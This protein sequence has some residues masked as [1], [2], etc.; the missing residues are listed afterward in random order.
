MRIEDLESRISNIPTLPIVADEINRASRQDDFTA[1]SLAKII[2]KDPP[3][4]GKMLKLSNSAYY[5]FLRK[6]TTL[7]RAATLLGFHT[8]RNLA[9][10]V[11]IS[12]FFSSDHDNI[13]M[14]G[15]WHHSLGCAVA[16]KILLHGKNPKLEE[17]AF[18]C[19][20]IHDIGAI[21]LINSF[22]DKMREALRVMR[23]KNIP[24]SAAEKEVIGVTHQEVGAYLADKWNFPEKYS[25]IIR[26]HHKPPVSTMDPA[27]MDNVLLL[28]VY[29]GNQ[30]AKITGLGKSLDPKMSGV[31]PDAWKI[32]GVSLGEIAE[33]RSAIKTSFTALVRSWEE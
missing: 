31:M 1:K 6:V 24:Q 11:S 4:T 15:L 5:G 32:L 21:I 22:P 28:A 14:Q 26:L 12:T 8:V 17:E 30:L 9:L 20:V 33:L 27:D 7:D 3:L 10:S 2:E 18:L 25:R 23:E 19:G 16:A 13:D 29:A